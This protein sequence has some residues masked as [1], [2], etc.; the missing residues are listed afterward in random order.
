MHRALK[1]SVLLAFVLLP[2]SAMGQMGVDVP[3]SSARRYSLASFASE[4]LRIVDPATSA[5]RD[6]QAQ[7]GHFLDTDASVH[8][9]Y[10]REI[11][12]GQLGPTKE[13]L[14]GPGSPAF[15][16]NDPRQ[17]APFPLILNHNVREF[18]DRY[19]DHLDGLRLSFKRSAPYLP[20][21][22]KALDR[23]GVPRD[24][25][26]LAFA[27]SE[28]TGRGSGP[29]QLTKA[30]ARR[31]GLRINNY[32]DERRDPVKSTQAAAEYLATLHD[33][34]GDW[35]LAVVGWNTGE[36]SI[37]RFIELRGTDYDH[38]ARSLPR[39]TRALM[40]RFMAVA[41]IAR[42]AEAYGLDPLPLDTPTLDRVRVPGGTSL[43]KVADMTDTDLRL[44]R[45]LNPSLLR[46]S[47][48]P[49]GHFDL[50]IPRAFDD[51]TADDSEGALPD[52]S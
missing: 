9:L 26:Y 43:R 2:C 45:R 49:G 17:V 20:E 11:S 3:I 48:P 19:V 24:F 14:A 21:M 15:V 12:L 50:L 22:V 25:I 44:I 52:N 18:V 7:P 33:Q 46:E 8:L 42:N 39:R 40:N 6:D 4:A 32:V 35:R 27:E 47:V 5:S 34:V 36:A 37:D 13:A 10:N 51:A 23:R 31:F 28:F 16:R 30:T 1:V 29:W 38:M 41:F